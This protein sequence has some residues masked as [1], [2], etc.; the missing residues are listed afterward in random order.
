LQYSS[1]PLPYLAS[2]FSSSLKHLC[3]NRMNRKGKKYVKGSQA[4]LKKERL[5][6]EAI[7]IFFSYLA[8][9]HQMKAR[10]SS[11]T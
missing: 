9:R 6:K 1:H 5:R 4:P 11:K 10:A 7:S 3:V 2:H 8:G